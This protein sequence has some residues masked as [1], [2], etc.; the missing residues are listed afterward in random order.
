MTTGLVEKNDGT[1]QESNESSRDEVEQSLLELMTE[2]VHHLNPGGIASSERDES[3]YSNNEQELPQF[4][5][6]QVQKLGTNSGGSYPT[7]HNAT[8]LTDDICELQVGPDQSA[9]SGTES[10]LPLRRVSKEELT[11]LSLTGTFRNVESEPSLADI[12]ANGTPESIDAC[13]NIAFRDPDTKELDLHQKRAFQLILSNF[14]LTFHKDAEVEERLFEVATVGDRSQ[15]R[16]HTDLRKE[17]VGLSGIAKSETQLL[18]FLSGPGGSGKSEVIKTVL[19]RAKSFCEELKFPFSKRTI[20]VTA[21]TGAAAT[22][23]NGETTAMACHLEASDITPDHITEW[24]EARSLIID[25]IS[26]ASKDAL[27]KLDRTLRKLRQCLHDKCGNMSIVFTGDFSQLEPIG[28]EPLCCDLSF[29]KWHHWINC[30]WEL[31]GQHRFKNDPV[32]GAIMKRFREGIPTAADFEMINSRVVD[33][34][35]GDVSSDDMPSDIARATCRNQ[36]RAAIDASLFSKHVRATLSCDPN[37]QP[38][39]HT[40]V[41]RADD[42]QWRIKRKTSPFNATAKEITWNQCSDAQVKAGRGFTRCVDPPLKLYNNIPL[43]V[44]DNIDVPR[45]KANG[46]ICWLDKVVLEEGV[47][48]DEFDVICMDERHVRSV[49]V[50]KVKGL[51]CRLENGDCIFAEAA[52]EAVRI[53]FPMELAPGEVKRWWLSAKLTTFP[54]L[55]N[56]ATTGHKLQGQSKDS[57]FVHAWSCTKNWVCVVLSRVRTLSGLFLR[58]KLDGGKDFSNDGRMV[59]MLN[60]FRQKKS[61][62]EPSDCDE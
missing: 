49:S 15:R 39:K 56:H 43:V 20:V 55:V 35:G 53:H 18:L 54:V 51:R 40:L 11:Q 36:D 41:V 50:D 38:P 28:G 3:G 16:R 60:R 5:L 29:P 8:N 23:I 17:L 12:N 9:D 2:A 48:E 37:V 7:N 44:T 26:F 24:K 47:T 30:F 6:E 1:L 27:T 31:Q 45:K 46:A 42:M 61:P 59:R 10:K 14:L 13:A 34:F 52:T 33:S 21:L 4:T 25:E 32:H 22:M 19:A 58:E 62:L 57:V